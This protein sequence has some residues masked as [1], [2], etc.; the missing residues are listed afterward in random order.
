MKQTKLLIS[1]IINKM[2]R[3]SGNVRKEKSPTAN[4]FIYVVLRLD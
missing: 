2:G 1:S 4:V 3:S